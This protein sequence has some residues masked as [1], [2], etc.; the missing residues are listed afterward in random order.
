MLGVLPGGRVAP[1]IG[2]ACG[3]EFSEHIIG[4]QSR[5][6]ASVAQCA[7]QRAIIMLSRTY[8]FVTTQEKRHHVNT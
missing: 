6:S 5:R 4:F 2:A 7:Y 8:A 3:D 1:T